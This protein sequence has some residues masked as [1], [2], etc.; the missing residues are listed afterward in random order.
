MHHYE[1]Y[2]GLIKSEDSESKNQ[3]DEKTTPSITLTQLFYDIIAHMQQ[4]RVIF[5]LLN[6]VFILYIQWSIGFLLTFFGGF[7]DEESKFNFCS[8][9]KKNCLFSDHVF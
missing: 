2:K 8:L 3:I 5:I 9:F 4:I 7:Y 6:I 1:Q